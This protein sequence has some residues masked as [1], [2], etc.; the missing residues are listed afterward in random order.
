MTFIVNNRLGKDVN[1]MAETW[2]KAFLDYL[3]QYKAKHI[4]ITF[5]AEVH[6]SEIHARISFT[7]I[8]LMCLLL[9]TVDPEIFALNILRLLIFRVV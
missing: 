6:A 7:C 3:H 9:D 1:K 8:D 2:E 4:N 5:S